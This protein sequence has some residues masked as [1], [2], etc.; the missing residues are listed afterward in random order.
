MKN[1]DLLKIAKIYGDP[2]YVYDSEKIIAQFD[3][4]TKAFGKVKN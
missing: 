1:T 3:R 4:L 2:V